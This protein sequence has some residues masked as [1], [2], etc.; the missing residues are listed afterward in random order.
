MRTVFL[1]VLVAAAVASASAQ[2]PRYILYFDQWHKTVL[3]NRTATAGITHVVTAFAN[4][5]LFTTDPGGEYVPF[6]NLADVR[7]MFEPKTKVCMAIGGWGDTAGFS[8]GAA[9][10]A[11]RKLFA[12]N[13]ASTLERL[14]YDCV[15]VDWEFPGGNGQDYKQIPN[16]DK[17][18]EIETFPL[19]LSEIQT[20]IKAS[21]RELSI[22]VPGLERDMIAYTAAKVP[23]INKVVDFVN[24]MTYDLINR[25][26]NTTNHHTSLHGSLNSI[27][28]YIARGFE[29]HKLN[30]GFAF[31]AKYFT[32]AAGQQCI[33]PVGCPTELLENPDGSDTG[34]SGAMTFEHA[35]YAPVPSGL[36]DSPDNTCGTGTKYRCAASNCCSQYG[37]CGNETAHCETG[38]QWGYGRCQGVDIKGSFL[39]ASNNGQL[40]S[41]NGGQWYWDADTRIFWTWDTPNIVQ[42][43]FT[44]IVGQLGL[45]GVFA[46][47]LA[48]DSHDWSHLGAMRSGVLALKGEKKPNKPCTT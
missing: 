28:T 17:T 4:S 12:R 32:T 6:M 10:D 37:Y 30:L 47:S 21:G 25:R 39:K 33:S 26:D 8:T 24:V 1:T 13:V 46:W 36:T 22:A 19:L 11:S 45:G 35:N 15:D 7:A 23:D 34:K 31:Y 16:S 40:D 44:A 20:A 14:G 18:S 2:P 48:Q 9:T 42:S 38:C 27:K 41:Y 43:K 3:P 5:S 29:A